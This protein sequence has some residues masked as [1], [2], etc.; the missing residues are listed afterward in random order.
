MI[1]CLHCREAVMIAQL[2]PLGLNVGGTDPG[3]PFY[4]PYR[5]IATYG[6][7]ARHART[8][9]KS[10]GPC[11]RRQKEEEHSFKSRHL[12]LLRMTTAGT[13]FPFPDQCILQQLIYTEE[14]R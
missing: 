7:S 12:F 8:W 9:G 13:T 10:N 1:A 6:I 4:C 2:V 3:D 14:G 11:V 5:P